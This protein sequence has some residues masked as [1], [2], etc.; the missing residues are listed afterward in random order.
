MRKPRPGRKHP[1]ETLKRAK[2]A[3]ARR[4]TSGLCRSCSKPQDPRST[5]LCEECL[6]ALTEASW[7]RQGIVDFDETDYQILLRLQKGGC[8]ICQNPPK[9]RRLAVDH[10]HKTGRARG[11][12]C[13]RCNR[14]LPWFKDSPTLLENAARY[15][16]G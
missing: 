12:L 5:T 8:A 16:N 14:G 6:T 2:E 9:S 3:R 11:L 13:Y 1:P 10:D 4:V 15:L 7:V